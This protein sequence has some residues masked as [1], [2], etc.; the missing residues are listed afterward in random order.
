[1]VDSNAALWPFSN[2]WPKLQQ[3]NSEARGFGRASGASIYLHGHRSCDELHDRSRCRRQRMCIAEILRR[4]HVDA[5]GQRRRQKRRDP[6]GDLRRRA[7]W[8]AIIEQ[9]NLAGGSCVSVRRDG[10][11]ESHPGSE[12]HMQVG[13][14]KGSCRAHLS[15]TS[16]AAPPHTPLTRIMSPT[17]TPQREG[18]F[19]R[20]DVRSVRTK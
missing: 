19:A 2:R 16:A 8:L 7:K 11:G 17:L 6:R 4:N 14:G 18:S 12:S 15:A 9:L 5:D 1:V 10:D 20:F 3:I 13:R